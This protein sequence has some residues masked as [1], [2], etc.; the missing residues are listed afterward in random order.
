MKSPKPGKPK[1]NKHEPQKVELSLP[2]KVEQAQADVEKWNQ[3]AAYPGL[4]LPAALFARNMARSSQAAVTL[5]NKAL[6]YQD[7][8][9][10]ALEANLNR[11]L[12][13]SPSLPVMSPSLAP[14]NPPSSTKPGTSDLTP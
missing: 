7:D 6:T 8:S 12:G 14:Q 2:Q 4:S 1:S 11:T 3:I 13:I 9:R 5:G 10:E